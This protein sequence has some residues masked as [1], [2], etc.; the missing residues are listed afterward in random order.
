VAEPATATPPADDRGDGWIQATSGQKVYPLAPRPEEIRLEDLAHAMAALA[1]F[2]GHTR[3]PYSVAQHS[4]HVAQQVSWQNVRWALLHDAAEAYLGDVAAPLKR[5]ADFAA[6]RA[7]EARMMAAI[8]ERFGLPLEEPPEVK[9][10]DRATL[11]AEFRDLTAHRTGPNMPEPNP[12]PFKRTIRPMTARVAEA[13]WLNAWDIANDEIVRCRRRT[14]AWRMVGAHL[15]DLWD[16]VAAIA[17]LVTLETL[18]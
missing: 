11:L 1:R 18:P 9:R 15:L 12:E 8:C 2:V 4:V 17:R 7:A 6:Y 3:R 10:A 13:Y 5:Q 16:A 14:L